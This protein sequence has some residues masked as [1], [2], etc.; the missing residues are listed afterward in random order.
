MGRAH[1]R[2]HRRGA[3][4]VGLGGGVGGR[5]MVGTGAVPLLVRVRV[6]V[7]VRVTSSPLLP[8]VRARVTSSPFLPLVEPGLRLGKG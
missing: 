3:A 6:R 8:L 5:T 4:L 2:G 7:R 1:D